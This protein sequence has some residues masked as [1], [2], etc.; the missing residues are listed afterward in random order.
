MLLVLHV[1]LLDLGGQEELDVPHVGDAVLHHN[2]QL[3][4]ERGLRGFS[5]KGL[6]ALGLQGSRAAQ[7]QS[8][9]M[10]RVVKG[11]SDT[12]EVYPLNPET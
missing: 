12:P 6:R 3:L 2:W 11:E 4:R 10:R 7:K 9:T 8:A 1:L 5:N